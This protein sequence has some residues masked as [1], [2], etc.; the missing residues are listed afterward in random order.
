MY[1]TIQDTKAIGLR[2]LKITEPKRKYTITDIPMVGTS[3]MMK[4]GTPA[5]T[6]NP[7]SSLTIPKGNMN[8][9]ESRHQTLKNA[10]IMPA[11]S[12]I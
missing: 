11:W 4:S 6:S 2:T 8:T 10:W 3:P 5:Q 7:N 1:A 12:H 9:T